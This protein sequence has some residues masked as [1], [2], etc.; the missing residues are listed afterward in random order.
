MNAWYKKHESEKP[1]K[2]E[3]AKRQAEK[4]QE[5]EQALKRN[6]ELETEVIRLKEEI[7]KAQQSNHAEPP[8]KSVSHRN[9]EA[10]VANG[11]G[12]GAELAEQKKRNQ[13]LRETNYKLLESVQSHETLTKKVVADWENKAQS[14][15]KELIAFTQRSFQQAL[16]AK[17]KLP[18]LNGQ[19]QWPL[20]TEEYGRWVGAALE[21]VK[22]TSPASSASVPEPA[23]APAKATSPSSSRSPKEAELERRVAQYKK[24]LDSVNSQLSVVEAAAEEMEREYLAKIKQLEKQ[25]EAAR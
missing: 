6:R 24:S 15:V 11:E 7:A 8:A 3:E 17:S 19:Q 2:L 23:P 1:D 14:T 4:S 20:D 5:A 10:S 22:G 13:A 9:A 18:L 25:V 21:K 16:P 12:L